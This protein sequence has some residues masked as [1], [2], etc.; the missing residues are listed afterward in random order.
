MKIHFLFVAF[1]FT[2]FF[3][4]AQGQSDTMD[5]PNIVFLISDDDNYR[6]FGFMGN[7]QVHTPTLDK[8]ATQGT[9]FTTAYAPASLCRPSLASLLSGQFPHQNG[10]YSNY[11]DQ[12]GIGKDTTL[13]SPENTLA[14]R[15]LE[16]G[17]ATYTTGKFWEGE[18]KER[19]GFT[20]GTVDIT[21]QGFMQFVRNGQEELFDFIDEQGPEK[22]MFIWWAPLLPHLPHNP[23]PRH[24]QMFADTPIDVPAHIPE[25]IRPDYI[26]ATR[27]L[28]AMNAWFD[29]GVNDLVEKLKLA[30]ELENTLFVFYVDNGWV[31]GSEA[32]GSPSEMGLRT[33][34]FLSWPGQIPSQRIDDL[35][36]AMDLHATM[37]DYAGLKVD[38]KKASQSLRP[39]I[40]GQVKNEHE[41]LFGGVYAH[42]AYAFAGDEPRSAARDLF[43]LY[44]R[45]QRYKLVFYTQDVGTHNQ[46]YINMINQLYPIQEYKKGE[47]RLYDIQEDPYELTNLADL[48]G[49]KKRIN[50]MK[51]EVLQWWRDTGGEPLD[52]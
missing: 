6:N 22:P 52:L 45:G 23:P 7:R 29:E 51:K 42:H 25:S 32:K 47:V 9:I 44:A 8:L 21:F 18:N 30:G 17:Y 12:Q 1:L 27:K 37:L 14:V 10:I 11:H 26:N 24:W 16:A 39:V 41:Y 15:L 4:L 3:S 2:G 48:P 43:A 31:Y 19:M 50:K 36:Y 46:E 5:A 40:E 38:D 35:Q 28:Y 49:H 13:L 33:P 20:H 34:L